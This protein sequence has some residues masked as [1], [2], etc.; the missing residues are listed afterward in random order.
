MNGKIVNALFVKAKQNVASLKRGS[1][2]FI[3][4]YVSP[5]MIFSYTFEFI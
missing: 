3:N 4:I 1:R 2:P 5:A